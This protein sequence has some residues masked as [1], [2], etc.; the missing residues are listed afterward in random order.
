MQI[1][2]EIIVRDGRLRLQVTMGSKLSLKKSLSNEMSMIERAIQ[3]PEGI[4]TP[5][6]DIHIGLRQI[7]NLNRMNL[8]G[9]GFHGLKRV[10][11]GRKLF[12]HHLNLL[13]RL[14]RR[15]FVDRRNRGN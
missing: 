1:V 8:R 14:N 11:D 7:R 3:V 12:V 5:A 9:I 4:F 13:K 10:E 6:G 2:V 15:I